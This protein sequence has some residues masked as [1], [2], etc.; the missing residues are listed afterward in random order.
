MDEKGARQARKKDNPHKGH[1]ERKRQQFLRYG[2]DPFSDHELLE[3]LLFYAY[4]QRDT[5]PIAHALIDR[6]GSLA[7]VLSAPVEEGQQVGR[8][9]VTSGGE[10]L[11]ELPLVADRAVA[12]LTYWQILE[13][14]L[15]AAFMG[16]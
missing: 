14:C 5:N 2:A 6:F 1:R 13:R 10:V 7:A 15:Q 4:G 9:V 11:T 12:R 8:M 16:G 3:V